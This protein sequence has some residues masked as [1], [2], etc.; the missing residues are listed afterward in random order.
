MKDQLPIIIVNKNEQLLR[1]LS[2]QNIFSHYS[3]INT[4]VKKKSLSLYHYEQKSAKYFI[5]FIKFCKQ[6]PSYPSRVRE[7]VPDTWQGLENVEARSVLRTQLLSVREI[8]SRFESRYPRVEFIEVNVTGA[9][10]Q[11]HRRRNQKR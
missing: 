4:L 10:Q 11:G 8:Q 2:F 7:P 3:N 5:G 6:L 9:N 1:K